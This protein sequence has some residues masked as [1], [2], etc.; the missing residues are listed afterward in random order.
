[1]SFKG[2]LK[3]F[4]GHFRKVSKVFLGCFKE[5]SM[6]FQGFKEVLR[7]FQKKF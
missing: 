7:E 2:I 4:N 3:K 1:M 5:V 6:V